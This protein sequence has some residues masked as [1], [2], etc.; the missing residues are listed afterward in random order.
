ME[1]SRLLVSVLA[2]IIAYMAFRIFFSHF[3]N[4]ESDYEKQLKK[5][6][7][8]DKYKVKGKYD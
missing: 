5:I 3:G 8:S 1:E 7:I 2:F 4:K 6:L